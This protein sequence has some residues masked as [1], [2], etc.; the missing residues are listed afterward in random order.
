MTDRKNI[1]RFAPTAAAWLLAVLLAA[2]STATDEQ[3]SQEEEG[4]R[5]PVSFSLGFD[6]SVTR[7]SI[8]ENIWPNNTEITV[9]NGTDK[10]D[11][12]TSSTSSLSASGEAVKITP[13]VT[14][15][16]NKRF[17]WPVSDKGW[18][19]SAWYPAGDS[20][21]LSMT[22]EANQSVQS[23]TNTD[24]I[25]EE[26]FTG[27]DI[28]YMAP[29][30]AVW[31]STV[32]LALKHQHARVI[33]TVNTTQTEKHE[34]VTNIEFANGRL[35][36]TGTGT[37]N[38]AGEITWAASGTSG[39]TN[40]RDRTIE[41]QKKDNRYSFECLVPPQKDTN[42]EKE[43][44]K[45]YTT[46]AIKEGTTDTPEPRV[47][48]YKNAFDLQPGYQYTYNMVISEQGKVLLGSIV[49]T[50]WDM[51]TGVDDIQTITQ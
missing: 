32:P 40:M 16:V 6:V 29:T 48:T 37:L 45:I 30:A 44:I 21:A 15:D 41:A 17:Y 49:L 18:K 2:C 24:G 12:I 47:Y 25:D 51:G 33:V 42:T 9:S 50:H 5:M 26:T 1:I 22:V 14:A 7:T 19:F 10:F 4:E 11:Y 39:I 43:L 28:L 27:G 34:T 3:L 13:A 23:D 20:P 46:G 8:F 36:L 35:G 38:D 31:R